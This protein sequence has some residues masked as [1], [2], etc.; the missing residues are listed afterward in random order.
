MWS[1]LPPPFTVLVECAQ[2]RGHGFRQQR[3]LGVGQPVV[4]VGDSGVPKTFPAFLG[5]P[6]QLGQH[7]QVGFAHEVPLRQLGPL[8]AEQS[9]HLEAGGAG[10]AGG[11]PELGIIICNLRLRLRLEPRRDVIQTSHEP[12]APLHLRCCHG[13]LLAPVLLTRRPSDHSAGEFAFLL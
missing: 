12:D 13:R 10:E 5:L 8:A 3:R 4:D 9:H 7:H 2:I 1:T 6:R 11:V